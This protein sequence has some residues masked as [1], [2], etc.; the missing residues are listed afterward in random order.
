MAEVE[1]VSGA[2]GGQGEDFA[3]AGLEDV[4]RGEEGDGVEVALDSAA[5]A[6]GTPTFVEGNAPVEAEDVCGGFGHGG[7]HR[8]GVDAEIDYRDAKIGKIYEGTSFMQLAT[9]AKLTLG[10]V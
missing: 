5:R 6:Y 2:A 9:I 3:D 7:K 1:D 10:K 8:G 4:E